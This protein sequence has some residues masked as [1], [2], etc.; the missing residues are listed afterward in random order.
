M[1]TV[2]GELP[3]YLNCARDVLPEAVAGTKAQRWRTPNM[4]L[5]IGYGI[6]IPSVFGTRATAAQRALGSLSVLAVTSQM[7]IARRFLV[8]LPAAQPEQCA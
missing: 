6:R 7:S 5:C 3:T 8:K 4:D 2:L 1:V